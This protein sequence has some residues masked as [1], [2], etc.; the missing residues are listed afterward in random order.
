MRQ[1]EPGTRVRVMQEDW[2][3]FQNLLRPA[4]RFRELTGVRSS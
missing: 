4:E 3:V 2:G 1:F